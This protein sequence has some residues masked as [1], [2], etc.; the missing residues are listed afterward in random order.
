MREVVE[1]VQ[2]YKSIKES[3]LNSLQFG[4]LAQHYGYRTPF[5]DW[6]E[7]PNIALFFSLTVSCYDTVNEKYTRPIIYATNPNL[8]NY[9]SGLS[10]HGFDIAN[11][12]SAED[13]ATHDYYERQI[14]LL[15]PKGDASNAF[16]YPVAVETNLD[17]CHRITRQS[18]NFT[19]KGQKTLPNITNFV[20]KWRI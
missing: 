18:G 16:V 17:F 7:D 8:L 3:N 4:L 5:I 13:K 6:T 14:P 20:T 12:L 9:C 10:I 19:I 11:V 15:N 2:K 1:N